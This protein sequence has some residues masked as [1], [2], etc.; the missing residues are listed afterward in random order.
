MGYALGSNTWIQESCP[1]PSLPHVCRTGHASSL[2]ATPRAAASS[3]AA[4]VNMT[5]GI[6]EAFPAADKTLPSASLA[7]PG[8]RKCR[9]GRR[10]AVHQTPTRAKHRRPRR[11]RRPLRRST[12]GVAGSLVSAQ[13]PSRTTRA[14]PN[15]H[16]A[17]LGSPN[18]PAPAAH[19]HKNPQPAL[20]RRPPAQGRRDQA[21][22]R[23]A[24]AAPKTTG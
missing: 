8:A 13:H 14:R 19:S 1:T 6:I 17:A 5:V 3:A 9:P 4:S 16:V 10:G 18:P 24:T 2:S 21:H 20:A 15:S 23:P 7:R 11:R 22:G 12:A